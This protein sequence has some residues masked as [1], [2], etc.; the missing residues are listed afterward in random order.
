MVNQNYKYIY[1]VKPTL[2]TYTTKITMSAINI[3]L[4]VEKL[5]KKTYCQLGSIF[6]LNK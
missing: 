4:Q 6:I 3:D 5:F 2:Y 1:N